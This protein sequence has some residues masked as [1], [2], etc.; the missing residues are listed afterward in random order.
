MYDNMF[1]ACRDKTFIFISHRLSSA[2][3]ADKIYLFEQGEIL[4]SG[5]HSELLAKGGK[6]AD[7][8]HKQAEK[9]VGEG[10]SA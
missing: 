6:Y 3:M 8:W 9:Y 10:V 4:E 2:T 7:M 5:T 1:R